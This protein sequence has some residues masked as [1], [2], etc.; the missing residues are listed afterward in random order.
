LLPLLNGVLIILMKPSV[1]GVSVLRPLHS[2]RSRVE[3]QRAQDRRCHFAHLQQLASRSRSSG[4]RIMPPSQGD[5]VTRRRSPWPRLNWRVCADA[6]APHQQQ[7]Q[8][9]HR[10]QTQRR[11]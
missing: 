10:H 4:C 6:F 8:Q 3:T 7:Q 5:S 9:Q 1:I 11:A 2:R